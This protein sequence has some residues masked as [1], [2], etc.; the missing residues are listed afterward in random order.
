[1]FSPLN[2]SLKPLEYS[3][4]LAISLDP[5]TKK[6]MR[7]FN[8]KIISFEI[9]T[10]P[11]PI[12]IIGNNDRFTLAFTSELP[13]QV[14][15]RGSLFAFLRCLVHK[16]PVQ[17]F[18]TGELTLFGE[19]DI[20]EKLFQ[21]FSYLEIDWEEQLSKIVGDVAA[22]TLYGFF[23][24][25]AQWGKQTLVACTKNSSEYLQEEV[26]VLA[27]NAAIS[28]FIKDVDTLRDDAQ[29]LAAR[30]ARLNAMVTDQDSQNK[31]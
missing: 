8:D 7:D 21:L 17:E 25:S 15:V 30:V 23:Q 19:S 12:F 16:N 6:Q 14:A 22:N 20:A 31:A 26:D 5:Q 27:P 2:L 1:M 4:N 10:F 11:S 29:R 24:K 9:T 13:A 28:D 18:T 3:I